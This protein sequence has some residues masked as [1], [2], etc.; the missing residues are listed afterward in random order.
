VVLTQRFVDALAFAM[1]AHGDQT[2]K[3]GAI[4]YVSHLLGVASLVLEAGGDEDM[5]IAGLL[6]DTIEDT[7]TTYDDI[8]GRFGPRVAGIVWGCTDTDEMPKPPWRARKERY[9]SHLVAHSTPADVLTVSLADK[10]HNARSMLA[11][12]R[13]LG[14]EASLRFNAG[15]E[16]QLWYYETLSAI[17]Q[18]RLPG[19]MS[20]ELRRTVDQLREELRRLLGPVRP[21]P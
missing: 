17:L 15:P 1:E 12:Y 6:H 9:I 20:N 8:E 13:H 7:A 16:D 21:L 4:P 3:G 19:P 14:E 10:L 11:D 18:T 5:A 2:R